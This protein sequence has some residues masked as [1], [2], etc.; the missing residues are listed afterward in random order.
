MSAGCRALLEVVVLTV[1]VEAVN[2]V[3]DFGEDATGGIQLTDSNGR[4]YHVSVSS[5][6]DPACGAMYGR[7][8][9]SQTKGG[10]SSTR[11]MRYKTR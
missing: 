5:T 8:Q 3:L 10:C 4:L 1:G 2:A 11:L 9:A 7:I 6:K